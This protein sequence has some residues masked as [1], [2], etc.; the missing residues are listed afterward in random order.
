M[1]NYEFF[2]SKVATLSAKYGEKAFKKMYIDPIIYT[3]IGD[4]TKTFKT[5]P[6]R[7]KN[8]G[9]IAA[10]LLK[11]ATTPN[12]SNLGIVFKIKGT[13]RRN[14]KIIELIVI[15]LF[16]PGT[17]KDNN[18][19]DNCFTIENIDGKQVITTWNKRHEMDYY[20]PDFAMQNPFIYIN[21]FK[22][23]FPKN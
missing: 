7:I 12:I 10:K 5:T 14:G 21:E 19:A 22:D 23:K 11:C 6:I 3:M 17:T 4:D 18:A 1:K 15:Q 13:D 16:F 8:S 9:T 2:A 20:L